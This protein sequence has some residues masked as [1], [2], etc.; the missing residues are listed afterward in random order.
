MWRYGIIAVG[1]GEDG[2]VRMRTKKNKAK[3][4][5]VGG[6]RFLS[7]A[8]RGHK[9]PRRPGSPTYSRKH[10]ISPHINR[11]AKKYR[12]IFFLRQLVVLFSF[13]D[14]KPPRMVDPLLAQAPLQLT[15][16]AKVRSNNQIERGPSVRWRRANGTRSSVGWSW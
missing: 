16:R 1:A 8:L 3:H 14:W 4:T 11:H 10:A 13:F 12:V 5:V 2:R 15:M 7:S 6:S 9:G